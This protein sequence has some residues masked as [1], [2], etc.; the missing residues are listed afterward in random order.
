MEEKLKEIEKLVDMHFELLN[1]D[2]SDE[3]YRI[4]YYEL[5]HMLKRKLSSR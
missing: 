1:Q 2:Y 3:E 5:V 4:L